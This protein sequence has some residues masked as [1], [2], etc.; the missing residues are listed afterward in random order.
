MGQ[1][2]VLN[3]EQIQLAKAI[4]MDPGQYVVILDNDRCL[5]LLHLKTRNEVSIFK[6]EVKVHG[7]Q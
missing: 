7:S 3:E 5:C 4:G 6:N 2:P 1:Y